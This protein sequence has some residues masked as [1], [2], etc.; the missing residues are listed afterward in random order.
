MSD[1]QKYLDESLSKI[2][3]SVVSA[4]DPILPKHDLYRDIQEMIIM[5]RKKQKITQKQLAEKTGLSQANICNIEK[6]STHPT[7]D[8]LLKIADA[9]GKQLRISFD[10]SEEI[11]L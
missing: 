2:N 4:S 3:V 6:G 5:E 10:E 8:S 11:P 1:F 9:L 7:I